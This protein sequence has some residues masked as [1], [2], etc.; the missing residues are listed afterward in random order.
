MTNDGLRS[1]EWVHCSEK[2]V[3]EQSK[4]G[5]KEIK[6]RKA[7]RAKGIIMYSSL[8]YVSGLG[9]VEGS[10]CT[11]KVTPSQL[12]LICMGK[13]YSLPLSRISY[14]DCKIDIQEDRYLKSSL[15]R[16]IAGAAAFGVS[17]AVVGTAPKSKTELR[18]LKYAVI[19]YKDASQEEKV[20]L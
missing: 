10:D 9:A 7:D 2:G 8:R 4:E 5:K 1:R 16:G 20:E 15:A 13:E 14:V 18:K 19:V 6:H 3:L 12:L 11:V 17:G